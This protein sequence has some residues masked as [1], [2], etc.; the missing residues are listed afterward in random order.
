M[1]GCTVLCFVWVLLCSSAPD[2]GNMEL[3]SRFATPGQ[4]RRWLLPLLRAEIRSAFL[5]TEP[6]VAS[7]DARNIACKID[8]E[9]DGGTG[10]V[11]TVT[12]RKW[13]ATGACH[14]T[15]ALFLVC[16]S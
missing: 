4:A 8:I 12:G 10:S 7:S 2:T 14:P 15:C 9:G 5:M 1:R 6:H 16:E 3:L 13:W 11:A